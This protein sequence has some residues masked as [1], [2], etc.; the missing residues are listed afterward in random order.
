MGSRSFAGRCK[1]ICDAD[2]PDGSTYCKETATEKE[3]TSGNGLRVL[4][5]TLIFTRENYQDKTK[6]ES[7]IGPVYVVDISRAQRYLALM[8]HPGHEVLASKDSEQLIRGLIDTIALRP[9]NSNRQ[10]ETKVCGTT[11]RK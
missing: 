11:C 6:E 5:F 7:R 9:E 2:G 10:S 4:E 1:I 8:I 3:W